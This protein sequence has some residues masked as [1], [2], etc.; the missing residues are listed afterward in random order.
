MTS[1]LP[2]ER[3]VTLG[4]SGFPGYARLRFIPDPAY[5]GQ[6]ENDVDIDEDA[7]SES[8]QLHAALEILAR[9]TRT[10]DD[11]YFCLWDGWG[12]DIEGGDGARIAD[13][14]TGTVRKG[15]RIAPAFPLSVLRGPRVVVLDRPTDVTPYRAYFLFHGPLAD[16]GN[17][18]AADM[19]P[20]QPRFDMPNPAFI[21]PPT[22]PGA[23]PGTSTRTGPE[24]EP[25]SR[26]STSWWRIHVSMWSRPTQAKT[27]R[28]TTENEIGFGGP[29]IA[30]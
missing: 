12:S 25:T 1:E 11:C 29:P 24:S 13:M 10:P 28:P 9:H 7:P 5:E 26:P 17:W 20:G 16:F 30:G 19:W 21:W 27:S 6:S 14:E 23:S 18:G 8:E 15:P 2:W 3:L 22:T 4:P